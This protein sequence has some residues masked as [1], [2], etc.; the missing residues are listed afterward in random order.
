MNL[1][2]GTPMSILFPDDWAEWWPIC[3]FRRQNFIHRRKLRNSQGRRK[4]R[5]L[6]RILVARCS[7]TGSVSQPRVRHTNALLSSTPFRSSYCRWKHFDFWT[8]FYKRAKFSFP[9]PKP[10]SS[11]KT[12]KGYPLLSS[13]HNDGWQ[14]NCKKKEQKI[15]VTR[16]LFNKNINFC[17][18][19]YYQN[20]KLFCWILLGFDEM[21]A[22]VHNWDNSHEKNEL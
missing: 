16:V 11:R 12:N 7:V 4:I 15:S 9:A 10:P 18:L 14:E 22:N 6:K 21:L 19:H 20:V 3:T 1:S 8:L 17:S 5:V 2:A 13:R